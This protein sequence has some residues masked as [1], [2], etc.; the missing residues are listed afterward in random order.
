MYKIDHKIPKYLH[1]IREK[2]VKDFEVYL[3]DNFVKLT[4]NKKKLI[5]NAVGC[6]V[7]NLNK[8]MIAGN[9]RFGLTLLNIDTN[10]NNFYSYSFVDNF[11]T[12]G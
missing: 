6:F 4:V 5:K 2:I 12:C 10:D 3:Q 8:C 9:D 1:K 7:L 11:P